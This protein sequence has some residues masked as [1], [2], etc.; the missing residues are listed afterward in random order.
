MLYTVPLKG[1]GMHY[2]NDM[3]DWALLHMDS[4][5]GFLPAKN[6]LISQV[7]WCLLLQPKRLQFL[8]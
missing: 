2:L 3:V 6:L 4:V 5:L 8:F 7:N 1:F